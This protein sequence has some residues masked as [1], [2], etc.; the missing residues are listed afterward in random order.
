MGIRSAR[1]LARKERAREEW[2]RRIVAARG[3]GLPV[4]WH[5]AHRFR[6]LNRACHWGAEAVSAERAGRSFR[7][8][9]ARVECT[10]WKRR[11]L[12]WRSSEG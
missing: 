6:L 1:K 10:H 12:N 9:T 5:R 3:A 2:R 7:A 8:F 11:L 4:E